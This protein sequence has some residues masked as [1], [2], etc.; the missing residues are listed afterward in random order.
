MFPSDH[1]LKFKFYWFVS[2][3]QIQYHIYEDHFIQKLYQSFHQRL[4]EIFE[5]LKRYVHYVPKGDG[6]LHPSLVV[7]TTT[8]LLNLVSTN[9]LISYSFLYFHRKYTWSLQ[10]FSFLQLLQSGHFCRQAFHYKFLQVQYNEH[11]PIDS[12]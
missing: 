7:F 1:F 2:K 4:S 6:L 11:I 12:F 9:R 8:K 10:Y 5:M 3:Y